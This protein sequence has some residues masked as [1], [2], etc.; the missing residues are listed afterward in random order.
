LRLKIGRRSAPAGAYRQD[1]R[2]ARV[3]RHTGA[4]GRA[5]PVGSSRRSIL[6]TGLPPRLC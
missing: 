4:C 2:P 6:V 3:V 1:K 5:A